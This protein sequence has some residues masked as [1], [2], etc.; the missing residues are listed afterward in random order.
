LASWERLEIYP[1][2]AARTTKRGNP[3]PEIHAGSVLEVGTKDDRVEQPGTSVFAAC[4]VATRIARAA[5]PR[6]FAAV[7]AAPKIGRD[8]TMHRKQA[9]VAV[10][11]TALLLVGQTAVAGQ[12]VT[13]RWRFEPGQTLIYR[14]STGNETEMPNGMGVAV[15]EQIMTQRWEVIEI[16][17][18]GAATVQ[19]S[20]DRVQMN[21]KSPMGN[22]Q[23]DSAS[24]T[25]ATD[26]MA[27]MV[28]AMAGTGY[29]IVFDAAGQVQEVR[30][31]DEM[32]QRLLEATGQSGP[33]GQQAMT[34]MLDQI[35]SEEGVKSMM[36]QGFGAFPQQPV[37]PGDSWDASFDMAVPMVGSLSYSNTMTFTRVEERDGARL[38]IIEIGGT[39]EIVPDA[40]PDNP[41]AGMFELGDATV[42]GTMEWDIDR[43]VLHNT[44]QRSSMTMLIAAGGQDMSMLVVTDMVM[45]LVEGG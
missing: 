22:V 42:A 41:A 30:G 37:A 23:A 2:A 10:L 21:M 39:I 20:V 17:A 12:Q 5:H 24:D 4:T 18:D 6:G 19:Q 34:Q 11:L 8:T 44:T 3:G 36:Q 45:E 40:S 13:L 29:T 1:R 38:A 25:V 33:M 27:R 7:V 16:S 26:P 14:M 9:A 32:R 35:A 31:L 15:V 28:T 43:G